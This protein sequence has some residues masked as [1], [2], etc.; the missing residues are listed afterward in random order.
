[1]KVYDD[2]KKLPKEVTDR[3]FLLISQ[4]FLLNSILYRMLNAFGCMHINCLVQKDHSN[5]KF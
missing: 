4:L 3:F 1:M 2:K 5:N